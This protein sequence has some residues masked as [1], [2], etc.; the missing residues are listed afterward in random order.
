MKVMVISPHPDDLEIS[1]GLLVC[2]LGQL[3]ARVNQLI[4]TDGAQGGLDASHFGTSIHI[5]QRRREALSGA[6]VLGV[7]STEFLGI[8][9]GMVRY[10]WER[11]AQG[12]F[13]AVLR[14]QPDV[15]VYPSDQ[16]QHD[17]HLATNRA[18]KAVLEQLEFRPACLQY[19]F[20][21]AMRRNCML[22]YSEGA[23]LKEMA[24]RRHQSQPVES[25]LSRLKSLG[26]DREAFW[27]DPAWRELPLPREAWLTSI[28]EIF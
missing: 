18:A 3:G 6:E 5:E 16:D 9:D 2:W 25:Y 12:I 4:I 20:W 7:A 27:C 13:A 26:L 23:C 1:A 15:L 21:G 17:D 19:S 8:S 10:V 11:A 22:C 14:G 24:I 28:D